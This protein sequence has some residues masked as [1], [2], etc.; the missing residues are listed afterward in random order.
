MNLFNLIIS[1]QDFDFKVN[2]DYLLNKKRIEFN[3]QKLINNN[4]KLYL[5]KITYTYKTNRGNKK[6]NY[7]IMFNNNIDELE[8]KYKF[9]EYI[10][11]YNRKHPNRAILNVKILKTSFEE[12]ILQ[13]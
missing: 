13:L 1:Q 3:R 4:L 6:E 7:K 9:I 8:A 12:I 10:N 5:Y 11:D 2:K